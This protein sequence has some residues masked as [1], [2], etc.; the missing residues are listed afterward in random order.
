MY[1][2]DQHTLYIHAIDI[3]DVEEAIDSIKNSFEKAIM[4]VS[5]P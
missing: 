5:R 4:E 3:D 2:E 1:S